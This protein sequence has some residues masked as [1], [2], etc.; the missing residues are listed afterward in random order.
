M[1]SLSFLAGRTVV[2]CMLCLQDK[3]KKSRIW[4]S[5]RCTFNLRGAF[6]EWYAPKLCTH[7]QL[8]GIVPLNSDL[9]P[10][11]ENAVDP[12]QLNEPVR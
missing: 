12:N 10:L 7:V 4:K 2:E 11:F 3:G 9:Y 1:T 5:I 6:Y 8:L